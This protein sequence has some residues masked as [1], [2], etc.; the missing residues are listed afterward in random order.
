LEQNV[1]RKRGGHEVRVYVDGDLAETFDW[2]VDDGH[3]TAFVRFEDGVT[4]RVGEVSGALTLREV[5]GQDDAPTL[6]DVPPLNETDLLEHNAVAEAFEKAEGC[7]EDSGQEGCNYFVGEGDVGVRVTDV[8]AEELEA[9][10][11]MLGSSPGECDIVAY[12]EKN[13]SVYEM[14]VETRL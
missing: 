3:S 8:E 13:G 6:N 10:Y 11:R 7:A 1:V 5:N 9:L 2:R 12:V 4:T 14:G